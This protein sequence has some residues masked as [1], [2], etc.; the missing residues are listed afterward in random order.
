M[1]IVENVLDAIQ[2]SLPLALGVGLGPAP[3]IATLILLMTPRATSNFYSFLLGW[4]LG[5]M[6]VV[7]LVICIP[8]LHQLSNENSST[9]SWF[10]VISGSFFLLLSLW[11]Y[12]KIPK[13]GEKASTP[14]WQHKLDSL[15]FFHSL[16]IGF[17]LSG[18]NIKNIPL[19]AAGTASIRSCK[20]EQNQNILLLIFFFG[21]C[22]LGIMFTYT[23][24]LLFKRK[25]LSFFSQLRAWLVKHT[26]LILFLLLILLGTLMLYRGCIALR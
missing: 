3:I 15:G 24:F 13:K 12:R 9:G 16:F 25:A 7:L 4:I 14:G 18:L 23:I 8:G 6:L 21:I 2:L 26:T 11:M 20:L 17:F 22:S 5:L 10:Q 19:V 1:L